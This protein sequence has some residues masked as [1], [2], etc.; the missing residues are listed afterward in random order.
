MQKEVS[1]TIQKV[2]T[3][4]LLRQK[5]TF[6]K[7]LTEHGG[8]LSPRDSERMEALLSL[9]DECTDSFRSRPISRFTTSKVTGTI[10]ENFED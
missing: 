6:N 8:N 4:D 3:K 10:K 2:G 1:I 5:M 7:F 9:L